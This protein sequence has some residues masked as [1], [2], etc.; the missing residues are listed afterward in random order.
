M[1]TA[2]FRRTRPI[3]VVTFGKLAASAMV[4]KMTKVNA[5]SRLIQPFMNLGTHPLVIRSYGPSENEA[6]I[7]VPLEYPGSHQ[8][9][10]RSSTK[11]GFYLMAMQFAFLIASCTMKIIN[12]PCRFPQSLSRQDLCT[13]IVARI[14]N[15]LQNGA[16]LIFR[17]NMIHASRAAQ[18]ASKSDIHL[19]SNPFAYLH[20]RST[21]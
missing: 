18:A 8:Y 11:L 19:R 17:L 10:P 9:G 20:A 14:E 6:F 12:M 2:Y 5:K 3:V 4:F 7:H 15:E 16:G 1:L 13:Q 21:K